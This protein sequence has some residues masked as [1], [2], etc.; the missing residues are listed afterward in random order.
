MNNN[1]SCGGQQTNA[2]VTGTRQQL[3][4]LYEAEQALCRGTLFPEL[5]KP[6]AGVRSTCASCA[7]KEHMHDFAAW[8]LRLYLNMNPCDQQA[9]M[10]YRQHCKALNGCGYACVDDCCGDSAYTAGQNCC[11]ND[12]AYTASNKNCCDNDISFTRA[13]RAAEK[14]GDFIRTGSVRSGEKDG[15]FVRVGSIPACDSDCGSGCDNTRA[16][17]RNDCSEHDGNTAR[18]SWV[19]QPWPWERAASRRKEG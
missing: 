3:C 2:I 7:T 18:W 5:D 11:D 6:L 13:F 14:D 12:A 8:E 15:G 4:R 10:A 17:R 9:L 1:C 16:A 19:E